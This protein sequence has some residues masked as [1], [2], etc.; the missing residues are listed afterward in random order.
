MSG[1]TPRIALITGASGG[2]GR[3]A[4]ERL[5]REG[6]AIVVHYAGGKERAE[7]V[8][9]AVRDAGGKAVIA[10]GDVADEQA[11]TEV[12]DLA[13]HEFGGL[14]VVIHSA[15]IM[16]T[17]PIVDTDLGTFDL[18][19]RV[20]VRGTFVVDRLAAAACAPAARSSTCPPRSPGCRPRRTARTPRPRAPWRR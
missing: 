19:Q 6:Y 8:A 18:I 15:G 14:D 9:Q 4:A 2:I 1:N 10:A 3:A 7:E 5:A 16:P 13:E 11:M 20:N 17:A 12:F